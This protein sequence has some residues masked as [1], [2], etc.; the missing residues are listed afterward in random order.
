M[1]LNV[2]NQAVLRPLNA[3]VR[4]VELLKRAEVVVYDD[5]G[6]AAAVEAYAPPT[7]ELVYVGKRGSRPSIKQP[8]IDQLLVESAAAGGGQEVVRLKGGCPSVFSR[9]HS[10]MVALG[11]AGIPY[12]LVP[13]VSS[14]LAA[15]LLAGFP[16]TH[17]QLSTAFAVASAHRPDSLDWQALS[18]LDTLVL[19]MA[20][21]T[22]PK[23]V[24]RLLQ[25]GRSPETPIAVVREAASEA[26]QVWAGSLGNIVERT[27]GEALSPCVVVVGQ[28]AGWSPAEQ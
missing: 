18:A 1:D 2:I 4:A 16:L 10:E 3:Q 11:D 17:P 26:Q 14:L 5:L 6:A 15:P 22:L 24:D 9:V 23:V 12:D 13:G 7:A 20:G 25:H 19:L 8:E 27:A 28:V 21:R